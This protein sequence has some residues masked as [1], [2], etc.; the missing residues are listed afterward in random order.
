[1]SEALGRV[2]PPSDGRL[3]VRLPFPAL[4]VS[5]RLP[6]VGGARLR[7]VLGWPGRLRSVGSVTRWTTQQEVMHHP[8]PTA[9]EPRHGEPFVATRSLDAAAGSVRRGGEPYDE[10]DPAPS[11]AHRGADRD[12]D[13]DRVPGLAE[14]GGDGNDHE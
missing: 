3:P 1:M 6:R 5:S 13:H 9:E 12:R 14:H 11:R 2:D 4:L 8:R 10:S 7:A